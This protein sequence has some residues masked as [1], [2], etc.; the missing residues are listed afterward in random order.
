MFRGR[1][2]EEPSGGQDGVRRPADS[3][4][5]FGAPPD[6]L[7]RVVDEMRGGVEV[8]EKWADTD[9]CWHS[10]NLHTRIVRGEAIPVSNFKFRM[11]QVEGRTYSDS[12]RI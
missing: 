6:K 11:W 1:E 7:R 8:A 10:R 4:A 12:D 5:G 3:A 2:I 9:G